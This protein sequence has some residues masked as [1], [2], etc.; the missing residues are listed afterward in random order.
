MNT[1]DNPLREVCRVLLCVFFCVA[2]WHS[3]GNIFHE[4]TGL[5]IQQG[6]Q[7]IDRSII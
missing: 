2:I 6:T 1:A 7:F 4:I 5:A 3:I